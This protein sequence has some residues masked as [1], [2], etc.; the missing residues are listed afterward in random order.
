MPNKTKK[1]KK[2]KEP[3]KP[4]AVSLDRTIYFIPETVPASQRVF[5]AVKN[6]F[7]N[8]SMF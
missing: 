3:E 5:S 4:N 7:I 8:H 2:L 1:K 6:N